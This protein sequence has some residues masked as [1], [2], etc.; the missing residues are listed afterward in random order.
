MYSFQTLECWFEAL[1]DRYGCAQPL[2]DTSSPLFCVLD[3]D[4]TLL[5]CSVTWQV[6]MG[7]EL[8][9]LRSR[10]WL[11][12]VHPD[13][14]YGSHQQLQTLAARVGPPFCLFENRMLCGHGGDRL[15]HWL[16]FLGQDGVIYGMARP[17][18]KERSHPEEALQHLNA[19]L[20]QQVQER[21]AELRQALQFEALLKRITDKVRDSLDESQILDTAVR[22]LAL[23]LDLCSCDAGIYDLEQGLS[24]IAYEC[25]RRDV[26]SALGYVTAMANYADIYRLLFQHQPLQFCFIAISSNAARETAKRFATLACPIVQDQ[27]LIGD[28]WLYKPREAGFSEAEIRLAS[29]VANQCAIALRQARLHHAV[30]N[31]VKQLERLNLLKDDF[32]NTVS[33]ELRSPLSNITMATNVLEVVLKQAALLEGREGDATRYFQILKDEVQRETELV[34][35]LLDLAR[36]DADVEPLLL[37]T[38]SPQ[39]WIPHIAEP[40]AERAQQQQQTLELDLAAD[41]PLISTDLADVGRILTELLHNACKYTPPGERIVVSARLDSLASFPPLSQA[42][43]GF[44]PLPH[45]PCSALVL[46]VSNTGV[47]IPAEER[48]RIFEKFYRIPHH[49]PW[50]HGG[51]GLGLALVKKRLERLGGTIQVE[52][53]DRQTTFT[54]T[55]PM[56]PCSPSD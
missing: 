37:T 56:P 10:P 18:L 19:T 2:S 25:V 34:N 13:D 9:Q 11:M 54:V 41:L 51:T 43:V 33:H 55:L 1:G 21:T 38:I 20:E 24:T 17:A 15:L 53:G 12:L 39:L 7:W 23:A 6:V 52:S 50:K 31:Q 46:R 32:L 22:E 8:S 48:D 3:P 29:Q 4:G 42:V 35:D 30:Q 36:L 14:R 16:L 27:V 40:F 28:L 47:E 5:Q 49:D 44:C 26:P 45:L